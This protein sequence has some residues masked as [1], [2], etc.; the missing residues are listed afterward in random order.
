MLISRAQPPQRCNKRPS[1]TPAEVYELD[2]R[3]DDEN[4]GTAAP[5][6]Q[7]SGMKRMKCAASGI[8]P[9]INRVS[10]ERCGSADTRHDPCWQADDLVPR[11]YLSGGRPADSCHPD[12]ALGLEWPHRRSR[13]PELSRRFPATAA[14]P[15]RGSHWGQRGQRPGDLANLEQAAFSNTKPFEPQRSRVLRRRWAV[16]RG[17]SFSRRRGHNGAIRVS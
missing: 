7:P 14:E 1:I 11:P 6:P 13:A 2:C 10:L 16:S 5:E 15:P 4:V 12:G 9:L 8:E 17:R 3:S